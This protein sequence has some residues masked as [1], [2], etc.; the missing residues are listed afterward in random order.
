MCAYWHI[1]IWHLANIKQ[2]NNNTLQLA[3]SWNISNLLE[4][5]LPTASLCIGLSV[6][7]HPEYTLFNIVSTCVT[8]PENTNRRI[9]DQHSATHFVMTGRTHIISPSYNRI[10]GVLW[11][12][13][14]AYHCNVST[15]ACLQI[16]C[17]SFKNLFALKSDLQHIVYTGLPTVSVICSL[18][19]SV[20]WML[21]TL[22]QCYVSWILSMFESLWRYII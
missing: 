14:A 8:V 18:D 16:S 22:T 4:L 20:F 3:T 2:F 10:V 13:Y 11:V 9:R 6:L 21:S 5:Y 12:C 1:Y 19:Y 7:L 17:G 15:V